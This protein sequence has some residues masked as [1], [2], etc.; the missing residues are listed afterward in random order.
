[1][2]TLVN[3]DVVVRID[4][5]EVTCR[6]LGQSPSGYWIKVMHPDGYEYM[7]RS[8]DFV[9]VAEE[10]FTYSRDLENRRG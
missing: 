4:G 3:R 8:E 7:A 5:L 6:C 2:A 1:M 10:P 9:R